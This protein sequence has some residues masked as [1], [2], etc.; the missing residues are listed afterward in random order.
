MTIVSVGSIET[1]M[2]CLS[3]SALF[4]TSQSTALLKCVVLP[5]RQSVVLHDRM[6]R[7]AFVF[8]VCSNASLIE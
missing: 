8:Q 6:I 3:N 7:S 4:L 5:I 1:A 2:T